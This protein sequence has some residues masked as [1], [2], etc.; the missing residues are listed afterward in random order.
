MRWL[1]KFFVKKL[2]AYFFWDIWLVEKLWS[3]VYF[4][5][6]HMRVFVSLLYQFW[7]IFLDVSL[8]RKLHHLL[9]SPSDEVWFYTQDTSFL[10]RV[11]HFCRGYSQY[12]LSPADRMVNKWKKIWRGVLIYGGGYCIYELKH[13]IPTSSN[14]EKHLNV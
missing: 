9:Y 14:N 13:K 1:H 6:T 11:L 3:S 4:W 5:R 7:S 2:T 12:V 10:R 8:T